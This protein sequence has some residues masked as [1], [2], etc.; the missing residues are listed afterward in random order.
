[1]P[2]I[3]PLVPG[4]RPMPRKTRQER[5]AFEENFASEPEE[6]I[7]TR[8]PNLAALGTPLTSLQTLDA[9]AALDEEIKPKAPASFAYGEKTA[10]RRKIER[11]KMKG[12]NQN[13]AGEERRKDDRRSKRSP[14]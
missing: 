1:M 2:V 9:L 6:E 8:E 5:S 13:Y 11:R 14:P 3:P 7:N 12:E 10:P 4:L